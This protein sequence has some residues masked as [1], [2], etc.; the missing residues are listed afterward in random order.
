MTRER[1]LTIIGAGIIGICAA[2]EAVEAGFKVTIVDHQPPGEA[3]SHGIAGVI[4]PWSVVPQAMPGIWKGVPKWFLDPKGPVKVRWRDLP[5]ILPWV[6]SFFR[7][8]NDTE[9]TRVSDAMAWLMQDNMD[10]FAAYLK[11]TGAEHLICPSH[12]LTVYRGGAKPD[13]SDLASRLRL[14]HKADLSVLSAG[15]IQEVEPCLASDYTHAVMI[16]NQSRTTD[17]GRVCKAL[18]EKSE[19]MGAIYLRHK[20]TALIPQEDGSF[21]LQHENGILH[22]E[23]VLVCAGAWSMK[24]LKP[25]GIRLPLIGERGYHLVFTDPGVT[26]NNSISDANAKII[27]SQMDA[28]VRVAGTAEFADADAP[29]NYARARALL[30]LAQRLLPELKAQ[31]KVEWMG[32]RPSFPDNLPVVDRLGRFENLFGAFGHSHYGFGMAPQ[33]ARLARQLIEGSVPNRDVSAVSAS[34]FGA[35]LRAK[36]HK[37]S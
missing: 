9:A 6:A 8:A 32:V 26:V 1:N 25:L 16:R 23:R 17:P 7:H 27:L 36:A 22:A 35:L 11:G 13:L 3:T 5:Q 30:P 15:E 14:R 33:T 24:L 37:W 28:G 20:V 12:L 19:R 4:S 29:P 31:H 34:R 21:R 2:L 10:R 18:A